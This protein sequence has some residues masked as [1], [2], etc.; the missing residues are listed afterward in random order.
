MQMLPFSTE[1]CTPCTDV[2]DLTFQVGRATPSF[3]P[4]TSSLRDSVLRE[5]P[6]SCSLTEPSGGENLLLG[7]KLR[8]PIGFSQ[9][10]TAGQ[11]GKSLGFLRGKDMK[12]VQGAALRQ[13]GFH[14]VNKRR[15]FLQDNSW[16]K[17]RPE[18]EKDE[19]YGRVVLNRHN[20]HDALDRKIT[21]RDEPKATISRYRSDDTL[22]R[23]LSVL[24]TPEATKMPTGSSFL[25][26][27]TTMAPTPA[28]T[29]VKKKRPA[30]EEIILIANEDPST[31]V[32]SVLEE[33]FVL[34][35]VCLFRAVSLSIGNRTQ[36]T[37]GGGLLGDEGSIL[38]NLMSVETPTEYGQHI[39]AGNR[40]RVGDTVDSEDIEPEVTVNDEERD[41]VVHPPIPPKPSS[42]IASPKQPRQNNRAEDLD[43]IIRV[44][45]S[46][47]KTDKG[48]SKV[49]LSSSI[50]YCLCSIDFVVSSQSEEM[51]NLIR[52]NKSLN[53]NQHS[54]DEFMNTSPKAVKT[55]AG[56]QDLDKF[57]KVNPDVL[58]NN[59]R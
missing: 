28:S 50:P 20:S 23:T 4:P 49:I 3:T 58:V 36:G 51:D 43:D 27:N 14:D 6:V 19:N 37:G 59:Q 13:Q 1:Q 30:P 29:P 15:A 17:K 21:E 44:A 41:P 38:G 31:L 16:I 9:I 57:I 26:N 32:C 22:D 46:L 25:A 42:P 7:R 5:K 34:P 11:L 8:V 33:G 52:M 24:R 48:L 54:L 45:A 35:L 47:Q 55:T 40:R 53:S 10:R 39:Q 18:E 56:H 2:N 12:S